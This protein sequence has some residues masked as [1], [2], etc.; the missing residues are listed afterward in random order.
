MKPTAFKKGQQRADVFTI[1]LLVKIWN[2][3]AKW[4]SQALAKDSQWDRVQH[5]APF[6]KRPSTIPP[7]AKA[8]FSHTTK[9][10]RSCAKEAST[11]DCTL[12]CKQ[13][14]FRKSPKSKSPKVQNVNERKNPMCNAKPVSQ[15]KTPLPVTPE[16]EL[17]T[18]STQ[19]PTQAGP[20]RTQRT[21]AIPA[22]GC[23]LP[24]CSYIN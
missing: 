11:Y 6:E 10:T 21:T 5:C 14:S 7:V 17:L 20:K 4:M 24:L 15:A 2:D 12:P 9:Q 16:L 8:P 18:N 3:G 1:M 13:R 23:S 19:T 22:S